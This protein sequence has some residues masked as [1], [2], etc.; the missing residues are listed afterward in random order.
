MSLIPLKVTEAKIRE[1]QAKRP[2]RIVLKQ[3]E[4]SPGRFHQGGMAVYVVTAGAALLHYLDE[5]NRQL[6]SG[7]KYNG[8]LIFYALGDFAWE[9]LTDESVIEFRPLSTDIAA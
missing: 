4:R 5:P 2:E 6:G 8:V 7:K 9:A 3:G 1:F